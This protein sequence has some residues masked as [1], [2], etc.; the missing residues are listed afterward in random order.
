[1]RDLLKYLPNPTRP[2]NEWMTV[3]TALGAIAAGIV[4]VLSGDSVDFTSPEGLTVILIG[5]PAAI[6]AR[7]KSVGAE[8]HAQALERNV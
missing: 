5:I 4:D 3:V 6:V 2:G 1:M 7:W 8:T